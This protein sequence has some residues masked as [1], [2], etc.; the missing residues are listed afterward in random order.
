MLPF[1]DAAVDLDLRGLLVALLQHV[2]VCLGRGGAVNLVSVTQ[3]LM[4]GP[5]G[6][7]RRETLGSAQRRRRR[8]SSVLLLLL[9]RRDDRRRRSVRQRD[10]SADAAGCPGLSGDAD[11]RFLDCHSAAA[12]HRY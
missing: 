10:G 11:C 8:L 9:R 7:V 1:S 5:P 3:S 6:G 4:P 2:G 12:D